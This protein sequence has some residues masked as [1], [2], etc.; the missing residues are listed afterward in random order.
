MS[1]CSYLETLEGDYIAVASIIVTIPNVDGGAACLW[2]RLG[3]RG[4]T[5]PVAKGACRREGDAGK[6]YDPVKQHLKVKYLY[7]EDFYKMERSGCG[8]VGDVITFA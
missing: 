6:E 3:W 2:R 1:I 5:G 4:V 8:A 7:R